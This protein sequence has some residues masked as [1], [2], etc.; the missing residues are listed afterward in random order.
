[1]QLEA[2]MGQDQ[3]L[4]CLMDEVVGIVEE[5]SSR[6]RPIMHPRR[7]QPYDDRR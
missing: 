1:V 5:L 6:H 7:D 4:Q 3:P 2:G